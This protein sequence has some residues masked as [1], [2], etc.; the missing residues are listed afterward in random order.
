MIL[1]ELP[2]C[3]QNKTCAVTGHRRLRSDFDEQALKKEFEKIIERG[4]EV[5]LSGMALGFDMKCVKALEEL[6]EAY[7]FIK[8]GAV[9]PCKDQGEFYKGEAL[10]EY[11]RMIADADY[12]II[13]EEEYTKDCMLRRNDF[14]IENSTLILAYYLGTKRG[15]TYYTI[16]HAKKANREI[17]YWN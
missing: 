17:I 14:L 5:F 10:E 1:N 4:Y 12:R 6:K 2:P 11:E 9:I 7:P 8:I 13:L 16:N 3:L 15:G